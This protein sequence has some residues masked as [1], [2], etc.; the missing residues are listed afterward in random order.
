MISIKPT[1]ELDRQSIYIIIDIIRYDDLERLV[2]MDEID[3]Y[4]YNRLSTSTY[5]F[6]TADKNVDLT[7]FL[8][9]DYLVYEAIQYGKEI[10]KGNRL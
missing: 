3:T 9:E 6:I 5:A 7:K 8:N 1:L 4:D 2:L 10:I